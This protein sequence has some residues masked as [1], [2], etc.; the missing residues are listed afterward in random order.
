MKFCKEK[1]RFLSGM[2]VTYNCELVTLC[3]QFGI[4][5]YVVD[6]PYQV[7]SLTLEPDTVSYGFYWPDR[8]YI[9]YKWFN[10]NGHAVGDYFSLA[11]S[12]V[13][14]AQE[15]SWR[16]LAVDILALP[17][18]QIEVLDE[19]EIPESLDEELRTSIESGKQMV[20]RKYRAVVVETSKML[21]QYVRTER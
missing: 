14:S 2:E 3:D 1:K 17:T 19:D 11:D 10:G 7:G 21:S 4:L 8:P 12:V 16:D 5:K 13:L 15:F 18:G 9:L 6:R 20:L